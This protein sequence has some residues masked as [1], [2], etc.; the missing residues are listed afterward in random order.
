MPL[1][2]ALILCVVTVAALAAG[3]DVRAEFYRWTDAHGQ[4]RISNIPPRGVAADGSVLPHFNPASIAAQQAAL[5]AR[6]KA[7]DQALQAASA[8]QSAA[9]DAAPATADFDTA[10]SK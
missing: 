9:E 4:R 10:R 1:I 6:L 3:H 5:R 7:R 8:A 2:R